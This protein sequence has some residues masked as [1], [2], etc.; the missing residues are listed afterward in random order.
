MTVLR[1]IVAAL[2][3]GSVLATAGLLAL[4]VGC[5]PATTRALCDT[6]GVALELVNPT[7]AGAKLAAQVG[8]F[9]RGMFCPKVSSAGRCVSPSCVRRSSR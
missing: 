7:D 6:S 2:A 4:L 3:A 1:A 9:I 5:S 8:R